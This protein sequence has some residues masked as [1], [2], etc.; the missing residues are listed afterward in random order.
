MDYIDYLN[1]ILITWIKNPPVWGNK[2]VLGAVTWPWVVRSLTC[3]NVLL[4][5]LVALLIT[6]MVSSEWFYPLCGMFL[7]VTTL[8][9]WYTD[10]MSVTLSLLITWGIFPLYGFHWLLGSCIDYM[11][12]SPVCVSTLTC[13]PWH[14]VFIGH[15]DY[16]NGCSPVW[17]IMIYLNRTLITW[18]KLPVWGS[19]MDLGTLTWPWAVFTFT[20]KGSPNTKAWCFWTWRSP[21]NMKA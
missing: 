17:V 12:F 18:A 16:M 5:F 13:V 15:I 11:K 8:I 20:S 7:G 10:Y 6:C 19:T 4:Q 3:A 14:W 9:L 1:R 21:L 2:K